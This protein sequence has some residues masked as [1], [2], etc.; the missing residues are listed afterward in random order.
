MTLAFRRRADG[1]LAADLPDEAATLELGTKLAAGLRAGVKIYLHGPLGAG[2]T[3]LVR[4]MLRALGHCGPVKSPTFTLL[5]SYNLSSL[6]LYH[7]DFYRLHGEDEWR[8]AG[9]RDA[10]GGDGVCLV[11][12][13]ER[14]GP[15][16]PPADLAIY[17]EHAGPGRHVRLVPH[18]QR[19]ASCLTALYASAR[20]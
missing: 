20:P 19:A 13:P 9:F 12:W 6:Y 10:F 18:G 2:K 11:E 14:A 8:D 16:L 17:L 15:A 4:G 3:T 5:E 1:E 7:F